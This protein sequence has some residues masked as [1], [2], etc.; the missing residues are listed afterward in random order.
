MGEAGLPDRNLRTAGQP[1][2]RRGATVKVCE[3]CGDEISTPDGDNRCRECEELD[4][5]IQAKVK[6]RAANR[7]R[8]ERAAVVRDLGLVKVRGSLGGTYWE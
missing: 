1:K 4:S 8:R 2:K 7:R 6:R 5:E 3:I